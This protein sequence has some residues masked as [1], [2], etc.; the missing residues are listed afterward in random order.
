MGGV[1]GQMEAFDQVDQ[2]L[3]CAGCL[4]ASHE[5]TGLELSSPGT[6]AILSGPIL[7]L[8]LL[9][10][11]LLL[12]FLLLLGACSGVSFPAA[13][14]AAAAMPGGVMAVRPAALPAASA[15][16]S[17]TCLTGGCGHTARSS[18]LSLSF[19]AAAA[20]TAVAAAW[21]HP[22]DVRDRPSPVYDTT[23]CTPTFIPAVLLLLLL[24]LLL[25]VSLLRLLL[26]PC[27][28]M[29]EGAAT[30]AFPLSNCLIADCHGNTGRCAVQVA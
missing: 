21:A 23:V 24:L 9:V 16:T 26:V 4:D 12:L 13:I 28:N 15:A 30:A 2:V 18:L 10:V 11:L 5:R 6:A 7:L 19:P 22:T 27:C 25:L 14:R 17:A 3:G 1:H 29:L 20:A 8:V